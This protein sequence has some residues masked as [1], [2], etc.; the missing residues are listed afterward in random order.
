MAY[1]YES[2]VTRW[3]IEDETVYVSLDPDSRAAPL[4][5]GVPESDLDD[6][7]V[8]V[9]PG[10]RRGSCRSARAAQT[11]RDPGPAIFSAVG[12]TPRCRSARCRG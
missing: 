1:V 3:W 2:D 8:G 10:R 9:I 12:G 4:G 6:R 11:R 5:E 7:V